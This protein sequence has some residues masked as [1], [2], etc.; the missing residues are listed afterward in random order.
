MAELVKAIDLR[1][2]TLKSAWVRAPLHA[3]GNIVRN[4][5][6]YHRLIGNFVNETFTR[7]R[8]YREIAN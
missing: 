5:K 7:R 6:S 3:M 4:I 1:S 2:V 8:S